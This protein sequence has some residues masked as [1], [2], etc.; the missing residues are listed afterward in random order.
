MLLFLETSDS[1]F[2]AEAICKNI[3]ALSEQERADMRN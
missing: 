1:I 2:Q 3:M